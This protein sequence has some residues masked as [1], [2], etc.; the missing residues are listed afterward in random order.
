MDLAA[1]RFITPVHRHRQPVLLTLADQY[2]PARMQTLHRLCGHVFIR[3]QGNEKSAHGHDDT[4]VPIVMMVDLTPPTP[5]AGVPHVK[6]A[7]F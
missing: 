5:F 4:T 2:F 3:G 6:L 1:V 7:R